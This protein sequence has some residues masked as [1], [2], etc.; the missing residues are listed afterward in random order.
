MG[1][2]NSS[3]G[4]GGGS[5]W[6]VDVDDQLAYS[7]GMTGGFVT[8]RVSPAASPDHVRQ[9]ESSGSSRSGLSLAD[10]GDDGLLYDWQR[11]R[12]QLSPSEYNAVLRKRRGEL[13]AKDLE[14]A[15]S[16]IMDEWLL[17]IIEMNR[18]LHVETAEKEAAA[19]AAG[20]GEAPSV[21]RRT[22]A[23]G[24][25]GAGSDTGGRTISSSSSTS[26]TP[27]T[28]TVTASNAEDEEEPQPHS[29]SSSLIVRRIESWSETRRQRRLMASASFHPG[30]EYK[31]RIMAAAR[32]A[33]ANE[34][35][36]GRGRSQSVSTM[37]WAEARDLV[38]G[39]H[40][41]SFAFE[42]LEPPPPPPPRQP[43]TTQPE[44][45]AY[46]PLSPLSPP[47]SAGPP[48]SPPCMTDIEMPRYGSVLSPPADATPPRQ[49]RRSRAVRSKAQKSIFSSGTSRFAPRLPPP[50]SAHTSINAY[51]PHDE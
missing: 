30:P 48:L 18:V 2:G 9:P 4:G 28:V 10:Y 40:E 42:P 46:T 25:L 11:A 47:Q 1:Q 5:L 33:K 49:H 6:D 15:P 27:R 19:A 13:L 7:N 35:A 21:R 3:H 37:S 36:E 32:A 31:A 34:A 20:G 29:T 24:A 44:H 16:E 38:F 41:S 43:A 14:T 26:S 51:T 12:F 50:S 45:H 23:P 17:L 39:M 22:S 8:P